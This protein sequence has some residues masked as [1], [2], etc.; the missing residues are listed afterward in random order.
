MGLSRVK[1]DVVRA[2]FL[3]QP[4]AAAVCSRFLDS[5]RQQA[6]LDCGPRTFNTERDIAVR[7][8]GIHLLEN[9]FFQW[10][11]HVE[12]L[13]ARHVT[14]VSRAGGPVTAVI[15]GPVEYACQGC[16]ELA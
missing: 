3:G 8:D 4:D 16:R 1:D 10:L 12:M 11:D 5:L 9:D 13:R 7:V 14:S 6:R 15:S 2:F